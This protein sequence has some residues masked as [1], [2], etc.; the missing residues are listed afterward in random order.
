M[1]AYR[2]KPSEVPSAVGGWV[3][4]SDQG[5]GALTRLPQALVNVAVADKPAVSAAPAVAEAIAGAEPELGETG[6][7]LL[8]RS[9]IEQLVRVMVEARTQSVADTIPQRIAAV[10]A[11][12]S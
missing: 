7:V 6:R 3:L 4:P 2:R 10:V 1:V 9:G 11:T 12:V 5:S 8:R